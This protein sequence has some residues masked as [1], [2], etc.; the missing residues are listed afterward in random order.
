MTSQPPSGSLRILV[1]D[2]EVNIRKTLSISLE[3]EGH[4]VVAVSNP[5]DARAENSRRSFDLAFVDLRLGA[6]Q[7]M[8]LIPALLAE[9]PW[10]RVVVI[11]AYGSIDSAVEAM[12]RGASD[13]LTKPFTP[14][15]VKLVT[16]RIARL[17]AL[18]QQVAGLEGTTGEPQPVITLESTNPQMQRAFE[19]ARQVASSDATVLILGES[20]TGKGVLAKLIHQWSDRAGRPFSTVSCPSLAPE[21][22]ESELFGH[23]KGAF[24]GA[25]RDNPGRVAVSES[26]TL[27]LVEIGEMPLGLQPKLLRFLQDKEYERVGDSVT[28]RAN[29]RI[30]AATNADLDAAVRG[31]RFRE[32]LYYRLNVIQIDV[33]PLRQR[34]DDIVPLAERMLAL[35]GR[36][37]FDGFTNDALTAMVSYPWPGNLRELRNAIERA[38]ILSKTAR[39]GVEH[40]PKAVSPAESSGEI[41]A[42]DNVSLDKLEETHIRRVV[43]TAKTL[44]EAAAILGI[45]VATLWRR[46]KKYGI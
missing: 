15:Q 42:G 11:T 13:Y 32:D 28:R 40:L 19:L 23:I 17:R 38:A 36:R 21:L 26:G 16:D 12:K 5:A 10:L 37:R 34:K 18:E 1:V 33:P 43:S 22:L 20:G 29:V 41:H 31:G 46:R 6:A 27:F 4:D 44:E 2:D 9:S 8:D 3:A 30:I 25:M 39:V 45:D 24:T 7:G 35:V 14:A